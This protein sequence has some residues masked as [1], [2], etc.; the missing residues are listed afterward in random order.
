MPR[1]YGHSPCGGG[2]AARPAGVRQETAGELCSGV[3][4][5]QRGPSGASLLLPHA[6]AGWIAGREAFVHAI[7]TRRWKGRRTG[8]VSIDGGGFM[9]DGQENYPKPYK[10]L[11]SNKTVIPC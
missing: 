6:L 10:S 4:D 9:T 8:F 5:L 11:V 1:R 3:L 2:P 7:A